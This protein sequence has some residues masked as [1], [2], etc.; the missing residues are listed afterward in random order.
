MTKSDFYNEIVN[1]T[2]QVNDPN[3]LVY[4]L[5]NAI[6]IRIEDAAED[7]LDNCYV[8]PN[9]KYN[10]DC[11]AEVMT[12]FE[13]E[14]FTTKWNGRGYSIKWEGGNGTYD[15]EQ[16]VMNHRYSVKNEISR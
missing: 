14:G 10:Q 1:K 7:G 12:W 8:E 9:W 15:A 6:K 13:D 16:E 4:D 11:L 2:K 5:Y 3:K